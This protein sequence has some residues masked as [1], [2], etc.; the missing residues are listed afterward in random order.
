[1]ANTLKIKCPW[2]GFTHLVPIRGFNCRIV[3]CP[4]YREPFKVV[5][6]SVACLACGETCPERKVI[7][8]DIEGISDPAMRGILL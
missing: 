8:E 1:M 3:I 2:C 4:V 6:K 7:T 5:Y